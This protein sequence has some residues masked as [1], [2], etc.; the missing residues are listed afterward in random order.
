MAFTRKR[1]QEQQLYSKER[2]S[3]LLL[4]LEEY[5]FEQHTANHIIKKDCRDERK[6][7]GSLKICSK[8]I[9]FEPDEKIQPIIKIPL[10]DCINIEAPENNEENNSFTWYT[11]GVI[12]VVS[13][14]AFLIKEQNIIAPY[15]TERGKTE[16]LFQ[17][18]VAGKTDDVIQ[19]LLQL[20]RASHLDKL[21]DQAA[22][23]TAI[24]QSRLARTSFDKNRFQNVSETLHMECEAEMVTPLV[25][26]PGHVCITDANLYF[27]PLN[28]YPKPVVH[29]KMHNVRRIYKRRH[30]LMPLGL[31]VFC[32]ENDLCSDI[33][34]KFYNS[35]D[36][37]ELYFY[38]ATYLENHITEQTAESYMLQWQ[39]G[40]ISNY[41][42]LLHLNNLADRSCNDLSQYPVFPWIIADYSSSELD[43]TKPE[44]FRDLSKP[45]GALNRERLERLLTR[46]REMPEPK[47]MYG[48]HYSS[49]GYVLFYLVRVA[50]EYMLCLQN[51]KFDHADRTFN[52]I[53]ETWKNCLDGATDFKEL[54]PEFYENDSS[55]LV[56]SLKLDLGKRQGGKM[57]EHVELPPW[58][59]DPDDFL[60]KSQNALESQY[61]SEHLHEWINLVFGYKQKGSEAIAAHNVFHPLTYE[62]GVDLNSIMDPNEK[63]ALLT[64]ILEFGQTPKQLFTTPHPRRI[65]PKFK[66]LSRTSN[67]NVSIAE[68]PVSPSE[69]SFEDLTEESI[70]LAWNN[71]AKLK[72]DEQHK[73]HKEEITGIAVSCNGSSV[74]TTSQDSTLKMF[75]KES[76]TLQRSISFSNMA[77]SSCLILPGDTTV[78][79][80]SWDN[81]IYFYSVAFGRRQDTL[82]GHDDAVSKICWHDNRLYSASWDSTVKVWH[83]VP[84]E[85]LGTKRHQCELLAE[86]EH[87]VSVNTINLNA[88]NA[89]LVSGT[90]EGTISIWDV[91]TA[92][93]LHQ[94]S[95]HS[96]TV[97]DAAFSPDSRHLLSTGEDGCFKVIDVQTGMLISSMASEHPQRCFKWDGHTVLSGSQ[98]GELLVWDLLA[99]KVIERIKG[100]TGAVTCMWMNEQCSSI[101][102]GGEDK[103]IMFWKLQY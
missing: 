16:Y 11:S 54:I 63:V 47:F 97:Y 69:E 38:I 88:A 58:A 7:R 68:S 6:I 102:T 99:G 75:S 19:T 67:H 93:M 49:P 101:I 70:T 78:I 80:S 100:H 30:G 57:V 74:F 22:M 1:R 61:V 28:G 45:V 77:L 84:A 36:R 81:H 27:Q 20:N 24:L 4:N 89:I 96:G 2:F 64:Q 90:K 32:T 51:G 26:N 34:L 62:G 65:I 52:S 5:Y 48:S 9:I 82:M 31:E 71:I 3:L 79:S 66:S 60:Q 59:L 55:F 56:N 86:L 83:C 13:N 46:Y 41:Q 35:Q 21:G 40:H 18:D 23:I 15:K 10:R 50:P 91:T 44:T 25:T 103:Q 73:I 39:R 14:Q 37:D 8:S 76:K 98:S 17:L 87:D 72:L 42:Y 85:V 33:Y 12:S 53:A 29:I 43:L 94:L 92:T 95:C